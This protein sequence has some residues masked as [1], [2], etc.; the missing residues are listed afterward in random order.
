MTPEVEAA[1]DILATEVERMIAVAG[2]ALGTD[3]AMRGPGCV[4][5]L[6]AHIE[7]LRAELAAAH[8]ALTNKETA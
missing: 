2:E 4:D 5:A 3:P 8:A 1:L 7:T 6:A